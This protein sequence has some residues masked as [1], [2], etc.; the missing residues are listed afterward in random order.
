L[1]RRKAKGQEIVLPDEIVGKQGHLLGVQDNPDG[2]KSLYIAY[3]PLAYKDETIEELKKAGASA[4]VFNRYNPVYYPVESYYSS[5]LGLPY[6]NAITIPT[7]PHERMKLCKEIRILEPVVGTVV[8]I[9]VDISFNGFKI[10]TTGDEKIDNFYHEFNKAVDMDTVLNWIFQEYYDS[11]NVTVYRD[12]DPSGLPTGYTVLNPLCVY[13]EGSLLFNNEIVTIDISKELGRLNQLSPDFRQQVINNFPSDL[14]KLFDG[15][16]SGRIPLPPERVS[17]ITRKKQPYER[18]ATPMLTRLI[19]PVLF[20]HKLHLMDLSTIEGVINQLMIVTVGDKDH[21]PTDQ[22]LK[23][24]AS[25]FLTPKKSFSVFWDWTLKV[26][27]KTP[28]AIETL[29]QDKYKQVDDDISKGLGVPRTLIDGS[30][31]NYS[32]AFIAVQMLIER[33]SREVMAVKN[34]LE[35]E[36]QEIARIKGFKTYPKVRFDKTQLRQETYVRQ[37]LS[38]LYDRGLLSAE[39][40]LTEAGFNYQSELERKKRYMDDNLQQYFIPPALPYTGKTPNPL[41]HQG[42]EPGNPSQDYQ[43]DIVNTPD[44]GPKNIRKPDQA[45]KAVKDINEVLDAYID[46]YNKNFLEIYDGVWD[47]LVTIYNNEGDSWEEKQ[48][49]IARVFEAFKETAFDKTFNIMSEAMT[50]FHDPDPH[51]LLKLSF[52]H[53]GALNKLVHD[54]SKEVYQTKNLDEL[55]QVFDSNRYR[56]SLFATEG[57]MESYRIAE[58]ANFKNNGISQVRWIAMMDDRVC[59]VCA[60]RHGVVYPINAVPRRPHILCRCY[61]EPVYD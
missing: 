9:L 42:R 43:R 20:K 24:V 32:T 54:L 37:I 28:N 15:N 23:Q 38:P 25:L 49:K 52:W 60:S 13:I 39:T 27:I 5:S 48:K 14:R 35:K 31:A 8:D 34:W 57:I 59:S 51:D 26:D 1:A 53:G 61:L 55:K 21:P 10:D 6:S 11:G 30:G 16:T 44:S 22:T 4:T 2:S 19:F 33:A 3:S 18:Y 17:R 45:T 36:Y 47:D 41:Q 7:D 50:E 46:K 40:I 12:L 56:V 29:Y 58:L